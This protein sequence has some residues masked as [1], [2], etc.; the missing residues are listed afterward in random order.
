M[1]EEWVKRHKNI[2]DEI[3]EWIEKDVSYIEF[4]GYEDEYDDVDKEIIRTLTFNRG[5]TNYM[6]S[7]NWYGIIYEY[8]DKL[9][10]HM[11]VDIHNSICGTY[12]KEILLEARGE[13][14]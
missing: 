3:T 6:V 2:L 8:S 12:L 14:E 5:N 11:L 4:I 7:M 9:P 10:R 13:T 1:S